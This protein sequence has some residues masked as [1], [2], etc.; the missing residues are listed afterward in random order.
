MGVLSSC[1]DTPYTAGEGK[2]KD[3]NG[4]REEGDEY[5]GEGKRSLPVIRLGRQVARRAFAERQEGEEG[6]VTYSFG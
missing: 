4:R 2:G 5:R 1:G 6:R 3:F